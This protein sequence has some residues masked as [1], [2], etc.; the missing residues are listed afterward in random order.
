MQEHHLNLTNFSRGNV[1]PGNE[2]FMGTK[3]VCFY[4]WLSYKTT[5]D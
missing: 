3:Y 4:K 1:A 5:D 2:D